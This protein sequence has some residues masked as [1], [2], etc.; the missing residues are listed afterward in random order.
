MWC[1][2]RD[3]VSRAQGCSPWV[4]VLVLPFI[5]APETVGQRTVSCLGICQEKCSRSADLELMR[6]QTIL[7]TA[8]VR[9]LC[10]LIARMSGPFF[11]EL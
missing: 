11:S 10:V 3:M 6:L 7:H 4:G 2:T 8:H 9:F 1:P 5:I